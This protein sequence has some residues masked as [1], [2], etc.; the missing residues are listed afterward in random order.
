MAS[1]LRSNHQR[2]FVR[3]GVLRHGEQGSTL[4]HFF[5]SKMLKEFHYGCIQATTYCKFGMS[6]FHYVFL[7]V[8]DFQK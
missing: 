2:C 4:R 8:S 5:I 3:K 6:L 7:A 1:D